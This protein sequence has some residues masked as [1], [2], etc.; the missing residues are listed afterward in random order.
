ML[1]ASAQ[2]QGPSLATPLLT[3]KPSPVHERSCDW[4]WAVRQEGMNVR[5]KIH[6]LRINN[7]RFVAVWMVHLVWCTMYGRVPVLS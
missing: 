2:L 3:F 7:P 1:E 4:Q 5:R 6:D